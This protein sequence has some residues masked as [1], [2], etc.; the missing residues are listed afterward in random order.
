MSLSIDC[1]IFEEH[2][3]VLPHWF[4]RG[5]R[6]ETIVCLDAHLDLQHISK[7]RIDPLKAALTASEIE[8][9]AKPHPLCPDLFAGKRYSYGIEDFFYAA[10]QLELMEHLVWV[11]PP[12]VLRGGASTAIEQLQQVDG[13]TLDSL[14]SFERVSDATS[15]INW[16]EGRLLGLRLTICDLAAVPFL[17]LP[18]RTRVDIDIDF[19]VELPGDRLGVDP[20]QAVSQIRPLAETTGEVTISRSVG[21]GFT[22]VGFGHLAEHL[23]ALF[24]TTPQPAFEPAPI[25]PSAADTLRE[26]SE[27]SARRLALTE[28]VAQTM[29]ESA[30]KLYETEEATT[31]QLAIAG[32]GLLW[33]QL[34]RTDLAIDCYRR[35][36]SET[37]AHPELAVEIGSLLLSEG[38]LGLSETFLNA[39]LS[40]D[41]THTSACVYLGLLGLQ[42][43]RERG[44]QTVDYLRQ[45]CLRTPAWESPW[46]LLGYAFNQIGQTDEARHCQRQAATIT[47]AI[48]ERI[49]RLSK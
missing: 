22:P 40:D 39:A 15:Q 37:E 36:W 3:S 43:N 35:A 10:H 21:S 6:H 49:N 4:E 27:I 25:R 45:A 44:H 8:A 31:G 16:I 47:Q 19:F 12:H 20:G 42:T 13:V 2:C 32:V 18:E 41:K 5:F 26:I 33:C 17:D 28:P 38:E 1:V 46:E 14:C 34:K 29:T 7:D 24:T 30:T 23:S 9:L 48:S 11:A